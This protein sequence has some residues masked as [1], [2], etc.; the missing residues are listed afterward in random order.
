VPKPPECSIPGRFIRNIDELASTRQRRI[1]LE[2][3]E[4]SLRSVHPCTRIPAAVENLLLPENSPVYVIGFGKA[5]Y[6]MTEAFLSIARRVDGGLVVAPAAPRSRIGPVRVLVSDHPL[7]S[8]RSVRAAE[9]IIELLQEI[10]EN[11]TIVF[12]VSGG[13][14]A[15]VEKPCIG[16]EDVK[17]MTR[18]LMLRGASIHELNAVRSTLSCIKAGGLLAYTRARRII[19]LVMSDV[20]GDNPCYIAS[21]PT[22][23]G[24]MPS[25]AEAERILASYGLGNYIDLVRK[26]WAKRPKPQ[27]PP[28]VTTRIVARNLDAL[29]AAKDFLHGRGYSVSILTDR[30]RGEAREVAKLLAGVAER[31]GENEALVAGGETTVTV[32][33]RGVGG[34]N[35]ELCLSLLKS[36]LDL[37]E[38]PAYVAACIG[39]DGVDGSS[40]VAGAIVDENTA[41]K[42]IEKGLSL[43]EFLYTNNS[44]GFFSLIGDFIDTGGY[45]GINVNDIV[46]MLR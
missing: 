23:P 46:I 17:E 32:R 44:Y 38:K 26:A 16:L 21:G 12:L 9:E 28:L 31:L 8:E 14:S 19:N 41:V 5:A 30:M 20:V 6:T 36:T 27:S 13:G 15:L 24:C 42:A 43:N 25:I 29:V 7:P 1:V 37:G 34:R 35:Q 4:H 10:P 33:G 22:V 40:P 3:I 11:A 2:A 18:M 45:T 39:T